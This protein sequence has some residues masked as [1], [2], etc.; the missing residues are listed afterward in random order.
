MTGVLIVS[1]SLSFVGD[2]KV[3]KPNNRVFI[4]EYTKAG[5]LF[6]GRGKNSRPD[7]FSRQNFGQ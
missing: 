6:D 2:D 1:V 4:P 5:F 3:Q 7:D